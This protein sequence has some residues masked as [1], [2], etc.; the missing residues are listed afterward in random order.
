MTTVSVVGYGS[1]IMS[2]PG[3]I[4]LIVIIITFII[5]IPERAS[6]LVTLVN[7]K[8]VYARDKYEAIQNAPHIV[9][10]GN[11][12]FSSLKNFLGEYF[13]PDHGNSLRRC[14]IMTPASPD[15]VLLLWL[16]KQEF[17]NDVTI[18]EGASSN[19]EDLRR[20][21]VEKAAAVIILS[22]K[23]SFNA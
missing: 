23:F 7:S 6:E 21:L 1:S 14:V 5:T 20:C 10:L 15:P 8:S 18:L 9:V 17:Y 11:N 3:K 2:T 4:A 13:H 19:D 12:S 22:D 16:T